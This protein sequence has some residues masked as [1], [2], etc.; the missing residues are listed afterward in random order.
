MSEENVEVIRRAVEVFNSE[1]PE[2]AG[3]RFFAD[4]VEFHDPPDSPSPRIARGRGQV[5]EQ[6]NAFNEAWEKHTSE[7]QEIRAIGADKVLLVS[8]EHF[9][10]RDGIELQAPSAAVFTLRDGK[11]IRWQAFW[12]RAGALDA[13]GEPD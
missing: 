9:V 8:T 1:G 2:A 4:D 3:E 7:P 6:F 13:A 12:S 5:R 11:V 10:G